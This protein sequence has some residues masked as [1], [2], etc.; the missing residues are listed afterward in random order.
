MS[1]PLRGNR[2]ARRTQDRCKHQWTVKEFRNKDHRWCDLCGREEWRGRLTPGPEQGTDMPERIQRR[3]PCHAGALMA[4]AIPGH[5][6]TCGVATDSLPCWSCD[7]EQSIRRQ[8]ARAEFE[9]TER[10]A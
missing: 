6:G 9:E 7:L 2:A 3:R 5:C 10:D 1:G 8:I 4:V